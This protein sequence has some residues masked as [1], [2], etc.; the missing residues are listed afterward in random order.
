VVIL[1]GGLGSTGKT[2]LAHRLMIQLEIPYISIDHIMMGIYRSNSKCGFTPQSDHITIG[3]ILWPLIK[4]MVKTN[5]ENSH[6]I[7]FEGFQ[8]IPELI[9]KIESPYKEKIISIYLCFTNKYI[10][11]YYEDISSFRSVIEKRDDFDSKE[12]MILKG[13]D[14][15]E[16]YNNKNE[17]FLIDNEFEQEIKIAEKKLIE[18]YYKFN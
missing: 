14:F 8:L 5:I 3:K 9:D 13:T 16:K 2:Y 17:C 1:I 6:S 11:K 10:N 4:E 18:M 7:I 15:I 12:M